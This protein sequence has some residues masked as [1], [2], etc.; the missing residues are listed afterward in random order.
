MQVDERA[1]QEDAPTAGDQRNPKL[2][3]TP[4]FPGGALVML[5]EDHSS[6]LSGSPGSDIVL[7]LRPIPW[8]DLPLTNTSQ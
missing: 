5:W 6:D 7:G 4:L 8:V 3:P 2:A 1:L